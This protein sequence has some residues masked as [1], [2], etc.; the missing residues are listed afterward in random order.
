VTNKITNFM[1]LE[2]AAR[3]FQVAIIYEEEQQEYI[4]VELRPCR[5]KGG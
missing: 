5:K 1:D 3:Q 2:T 4:L